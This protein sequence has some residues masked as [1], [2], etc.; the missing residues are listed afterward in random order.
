MFPYPLLW[1]ERNQLLVKLP[2]LH[3]VDA[4]Q[5]K[6]RTNVAV[7]MSRNNALITSDYFKSYV[8]VPYLF[9]SYVQD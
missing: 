5:N 7:R 9:N 4:S 8:F 6:T 2:E 1:T 3:G